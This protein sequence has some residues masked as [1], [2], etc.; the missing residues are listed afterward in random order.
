MR[1]REALRHAKAFVRREYPELA[2][3]YIEVCRES[4]AEGRRATW[5]FGVHVDEEDFDL[6]AKLDVEP[7]HSWTGYVFYG[8]LDPDRPTVQGLS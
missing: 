7:R 6:Q 3:C 8:D 2:D 4:D 1:A 5:S